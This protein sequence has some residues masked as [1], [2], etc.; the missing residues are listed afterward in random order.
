[1]KRDCDNTAVRVQNFCDIKSRWLQNFCSIR[2]GKGAAAAEFLRHQMKRP[3][4]SLGKRY[5]DRVKNTRVDA[6]VQIKSLMSIVNITE[7]QEI[8]CISCL[9]GNPLEVSHSA[10]RDK[11]LKYQKRSYGWWQG[12]KGRPEGSKQKEN[13][14]KKR[15]CKT[16]TLSIYRKP[17]LESAWYQPG[18]ARTTGYPHVELPYLC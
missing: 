8:I 9:V 16:L 5:G 18:C 14:L 3:Q 15:S 13:Q 2:L 6:K 10:R 7:G 11:W 12:Q 4:N 17:R 1:M